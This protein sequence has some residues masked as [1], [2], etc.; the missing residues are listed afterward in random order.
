MALDFLVSPIPWDYIYQGMLDE[1][2]PGNFYLQAEETV[3]RSI[4]PTEFI[5]STDS[6]DTVEIRINN[7]LVL[8]H[9]PRSRLDRVSIQLFD[10]PDVNLIQVTN[11]VDLPVNLAIAS[12]HIAK[13][14]FVFS[15]ELYEFS[16]FTVEK[17]FNLLRS[18]WAA[19]IAEY[20]LPWQRALP[21]VRSWRSMSVKMEALTLFQEQATRGGIPDLVTG[22]CQSTPVIMKPVNPETW[23]P[24][25]YQ[26]QSAAHDV[27]GFDFHVWLPNICFNQWL[28][29]ISL[30]NNVDYYQMRSVTE[31]AVMLQIDKPQQIYEQ[32]LFGQPDL[33]GGGRMD[34]LGPGC[35]IL[36]LIDFL[37]CMDGIEV[38]GET[39]L[40]SDFAL[41]FWASPFDLQVE[42][43]GI[44]GQFFDSDTDFDGDFGP[45]DGTYDVDLLTNF[46]VGTSTTKRFDFGIC[47]DSYTTLARD[48]DEFS[49]CEDGPDASVFSTMAIDEDTTSAVTPINP[50]FGG[51][52][53]GLLGNPYFGV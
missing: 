52:D 35:S 14:M 41:C 38:A 11:G 6:N 16:G 23:Q 44:G 30:A 43:P 42:P 51:D 36:G 46:W 25:L 33:A 37:G 49:C 8:T 32:H 53:P 2:P 3:P 9:I 21:D 39:L 31:E 12:T 27:T 5:L 18:P 24:D 48:P 22:F 1:V 4:L 20:Q 50:L 29:F 15:K 7:K 26:P 13:Y 40:F 47:L 10:P 17:F 34:N 28:A 19:F 45:L